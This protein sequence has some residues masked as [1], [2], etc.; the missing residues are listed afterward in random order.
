MKTNPGGQLAPEQIVGR[1]ALIAG[2][3]D[4]LAGRSI[5]MNDLRRI[6]KTQIMVKMR[7]ELPSG[8]LAVKCDLGGTHTAAEF[9]TL[10]Y[11]GSSEVLGRRSKALRR[12]GAL[13]G[14]AAGMDIAGVSS[15]PMVRRPRGRMFS[16][17]PLRTSKKP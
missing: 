1:D 12:M 10:A 6:G 4:I 8:W 14:K 17:G 11:K 16:A 15:C 3:W 9:A 5:S 2:M 13:L 7:A